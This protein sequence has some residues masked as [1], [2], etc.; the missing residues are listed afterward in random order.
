MFRVVFSLMA[1]P[2]AASAQMHKIIAATY[3]PAPSPEPCRINVLFN[4][5]LAAPPAAVT[6]H[7]ENQNAIAATL[8]LAPGG[9][10]VVEIRF[11]QPCPKNVAD[12]V[13]PSVTFADGATQANITHPV[14]KGGDATKIFID[15]MQKV[16]QTQAEKTIFASGLVTSASSG[17]A[18][19]ADVNL[20]SP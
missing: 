7:D 12:V 9:S 4:S 3:A 5:L 2:L 13:F 14:L 15:L 20:N 17:A 19:A 1:F 18:G 16:S 8:S 10:R 6:V 11:P